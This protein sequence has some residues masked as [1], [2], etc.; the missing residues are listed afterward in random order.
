MGTKPNLDTSVLVISSR[1]LF[2][3]SAPTVFFMCHS[4]LILIFF[5][6]LILQFCAATVR[7][8]CTETRPG[9]ATQ[10]PVFPWEP[11]GVSCTQDQGQ[12]LPVW[13]QP[14]P[15]KVSMV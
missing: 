15:L 6:N 8:S 3:N 2:F 4:A 13:L 10:S 7:P 9:R 5:Q 12:G 14:D 1:A 11:A